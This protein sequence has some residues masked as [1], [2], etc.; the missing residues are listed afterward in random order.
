M[1]G[2]QLTTDIDPVT[3]EGNFTDLTLSETGRYFLIF[4][5]TSHPSDYDLEVFSSEIEVY[6]ADYVE[7][8]IEEEKTAQ[9]TFLE[10]FSLV[11]GNEDLFKGVMY[12]AIFSNYSTVKFSFTSVV[13]GIYFN[14]VGY[15]DHCVSNAITYI[16]NSQYNYC[17]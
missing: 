11:S 16:L 7:P 5:F 14:I 17:E 4:Y 2:T 15:S 1:E 8:V 6:E 13:Q 10:Q 9:I 3:A 12:N